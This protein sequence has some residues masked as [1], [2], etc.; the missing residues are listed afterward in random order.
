MLGRKGKRKCL[1][2]QYEGDMKTW[3]GS[4]NRPQFITILLLVVFFIPGL[5]FIIWNWGKFMCPNCGALAK[6]TPFKIV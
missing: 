1:V 5:I 2:C 6:N 4:Y 3:L